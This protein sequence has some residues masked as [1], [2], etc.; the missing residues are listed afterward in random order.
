MKWKFGS[1]LSVA[2]EG[3]GKPE[4]GSYLHYRANAVRALAGAQRLIARGEGSQ[5]D[6]HEEEDSDGEPEIN[7]AGLTSDPYCVVRYG[8]TAQRT[9]YKRKRLNP[10]WNTGFIFHNVKPDTDVE[11]E[12][13]DYDDITADDFMGKASLAIKASAIEKQEEHE[14]W[15]SLANAN[16]NRESGLGELKVSLKIFDTSG[17]GHAQAMVQIMEAKGLPGTERENKY[18]DGIA[19]TLG[20][21][22]T[23]VNH[24]YVKRRK[25]WLKV[26]AQWR[27]EFLESIQIHGEMDELGKELPP[28]GTDIFLHLFT[29]LWK[30]VFSMIP[31]KDLYGGKLAFGISILLIGALTYVVGEI[32]G[33]FG[34]VVG[35]KDAVT[36]ITFVALGTSLP[37]TFA[38][39]LA[40]TNEDTA[41]ASLGNITGSNSVNVFL[42]IGLPWVISSGYAL[43][44]GEKFIVSS[45]GFGLGVCTFCGCAFLCLGTLMYRRFTVGA[46][47]GGDPGK[48]MATSVFFLA[49]W[50]IYIIV[51]SMVIY[52]DI[53]DPF[54]RR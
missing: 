3:E 4:H 27:E 37:D 28:T 29:L 21:S 19:K 20:R 52:G 14:V 54:A 36:A 17:G 18:L 40:A 34:C 22:F 41:D 9:K 11:F 53:E 25:A 43:S 24:R 33:L 31:P 23:I 50:L 30:V 6:I 2:P 49:L 42:G 12:I 35:L 39:K 32:A 1:G 16:G 5:P 15:L 7:S 46:E 38:S 8:R 26:K 47:L 45:P 44:M 10:K 51:S 48:A 13:W